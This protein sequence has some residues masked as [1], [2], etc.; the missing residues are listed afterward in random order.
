MQSYQ[1]V[2]FFFWY[3]QDVKLL[4][5][6]ETVE[7]YILLEAFQIGTSNTLQN[8]QISFTKLDLVN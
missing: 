1:D 4:Q 6:L 5:S 8:H 2:I 7:V 3:N